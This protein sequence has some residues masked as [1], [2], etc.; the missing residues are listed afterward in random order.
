MNVA[1]VGHLEWGRFVRVE[2]LPAPGEIIH[3]DESWEE[4]A[5]GGSV[6]AMQLAALAGE[7]MFFTA[8][9]DDELGQR[10]VR[11]LQASGV[12]VHAS[13]LPG[14]KTKDIFV[15]IDGDKERTITVTGNVVPD[16]NDTSLPWEKL[17]E[18]DA[19]YFVNGNQAALKA[20]R[21]AK[22][23]LSTARILPLLKSSGVPLDVLVHSKTD[24]GEAYH[25]GDITPAPKIVVTTN[26][27]SGGYTNSGV[28]Y[29][30]E[31]VP[32]KD[33]ADT[34]GCG[35]SFAAGLAFALGENQDLSEA[36]QFAAQCGA[37]ASKRRGSFGNG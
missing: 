5:G 36:L 25:S 1:V 34:Y 27:T 20:A 28:K 19:V 3:T 35:D 10:A 31:I 26:G 16:G 32:K 14:I 17:A 11:Q 12:E 29:Q 9:G 4:V 6:G 15:Y 8:V 18:M 23:L 33:I 7:C 21:Q 37:A 13:I 22:V 24:T 2:R 30:S